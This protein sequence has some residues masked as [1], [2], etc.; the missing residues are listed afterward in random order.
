MVLVIVKDGSNLP[1]EGI[2]R[3]A[4]I[5]SFSFNSAHIDRSGQ[6]CWTYQRCYPR[7][8][9]TFLRKRTKPLTF[10]G[11]VKC[12]SADRLGGEFSGVL[13]DVCTAQSLQ[14]CTDTLRVPQRR[15]KH[16]QSFSKERTRRSRPPG[17]WRGLGSSLQ[18]VASS[19]SYRLGVGQR[20]L[21]SRA[22]GAFFPGAP[23]SLSG[24]EN[25]EM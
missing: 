15:K 11:A 14:R 9:M 7:R 23:K 8:T 12:A 22:L 10:S 17:P 6:L 3:V 13:L 18:F 2:S 25:R 16:P 4:R 5:E 24:L 20:L 1:A 21:P 19:L